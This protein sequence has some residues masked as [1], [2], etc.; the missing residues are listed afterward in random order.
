MSLAGE[1]QASHSLFS[2]QLPEYSPP[3]PGLVCCPVCL[4]ECSSS[5][6]VQGPVCEKQGPH[7]RAHCISH[8]P[9]HQPCRPLAGFTPKAE[10]A[11]SATAGSGALAQSLE[12]CVLKINVNFTPFST[13]NL[14]MFV[15]L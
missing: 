11:V 3:T 10:E 9:F 1:S 4:I 15:F 5:H 14:S 13:H 7:R 6:L 2:L 12:P 8:F